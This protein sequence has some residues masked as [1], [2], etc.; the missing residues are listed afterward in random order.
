MVTHF[1][2]PKL[3]PLFLLWN[4]SADFIITESVQVQAGR[5]PGSI[6]DTKFAMNQGFT[7]KRQ[8][9]KSVF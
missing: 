9:S 6:P 5:M 7:K 4:H 8:A 3:K 1:F 2:P